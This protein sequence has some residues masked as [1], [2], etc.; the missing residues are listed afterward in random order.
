MMQSNE[1]ATEV[2]GSCGARL[3]QARETAGLSIED[4][5]ARLKMPSR[6]VRSLESD[7]IASLG[8]PVFVRGQLRSY[9]R[10]VG[11][12]LESQLS[13]TP[14]A[15]TAPSELVSHTHTPRY[16]RVFEQ[17]TR[18]AVYIVMTAAIAVPI[19]IATRHPNSNSTVQSLDMAALP[20][21]PAGAAPSQTGAAAQA[22][23][24]PP[25]RTPLIASMTPPLPQAQ[26]QAAKTLNLKFSGDSW[27]QIV[28]TDGS[29]L[30]EG[31]LGAGQERSYTPGDVASVR[32]GNTSAVEVR[33][34]GQPVDLA[35][36]SRANV[37]RFTLSSD[38]SLAPVSD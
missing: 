25:Q 19:W 6:V 38:G 36:F 26:A 33:N 7:D 16:R 28:G 24:T 4:V 32:L 8:A 15:S 18:R 27:V 13:G 37:A 10:L 21:G 30:E 12:D 23:S 29:K 31:I 11:I 34:A 17:T 9:A 5:A 3:K 35:P 22:D 1:F 14:V 2:G 20:A